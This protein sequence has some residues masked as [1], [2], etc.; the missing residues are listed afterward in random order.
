MCVCIVCVGMFS[1]KSGSGKTFTADRLMVKMLARSTKS[2]W[3]QDI[4]KVLI[5]DTEKRKES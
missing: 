2:E 3:I 1:G 4:R 5:Y